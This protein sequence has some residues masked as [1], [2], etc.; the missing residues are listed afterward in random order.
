M[1]FHSAWLAPL[2]LL[3]MLPATL[4]LAAES[5]AERPIVD[6]SRKVIRSAPDRHFGRAALEELPAATWL[7]AY[8]EADHHAKNRDGRLHLMVST[9]HGKTWSGEDHHAD[10]NPIQ[11]FPA[12]PP[13]AGPG[14]PTG[15]GEPWLYQAP[16]GTLILHCWKVQYSDRSK[17]GGTWQITS[18]DG[19]KTWSEWSQVDFQ[20]IEQDNDVFATDDHFVHEGTIYAG[21]RQYAKGKW[22]NMLIVSEDNGRTWRKLSDITT[23]QH[24]TSEVGLELIRNER[25]VA[26]LNTKRRTAVYRTFSD[27][28]GETWDTPEPIQE[29]TKIWDRCR[30]FSRNRLLGNAG[31]AGD[32]VLLGFGDQALV[33]GKSMPRRNVLWLSHDSGESWSGPIGLDKRT[34]D[35]GYGDVLY[36]PT[37][38]TYCFYSYHGSME[39]ASLVEYR[40]KLRDKTQ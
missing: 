6:L 35:A 9:D 38:G 3:C 40:F 21:A 33:P 39:E 32:T 37:N 25:V 13:G 31:S 27:D 34:E 4:I 16:D 10:G 36:D 15:P 14:E 18:S 20:G 11:R 26:V 30:I 29:Q 17:N 22:K 28:L 12:W 24:N 19:G 2:L 23:Y 7:L 1:R 5:D 8:R